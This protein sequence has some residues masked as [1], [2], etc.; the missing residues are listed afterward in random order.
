MGFCERNR[1]QLEE[2]GVDPARLP[3]GQYFTERFPVLHVGDVPDWRDLSAWSLRIGGLA[4]AAAIADVLAPFDIARIGSSPA[5]RCVQTVQPLADKRSLRID[6]HPALGEEA[7]TEQTW[8][9]VTELITLDGD[10]V[11]CSHGNIIPPLLDRLHRRGVEVVAE[12]WSCHK[13]SIWTLDVEGGEILRAVQT[14]S[15]P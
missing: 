10:T 13:G 4:Q 5:V 12:E 3:P 1:R 14:L 8:Q 11:A 7:S 6:L 2:R 9:L 15:R